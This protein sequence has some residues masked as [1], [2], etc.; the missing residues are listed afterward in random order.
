MPR[1]SVFSV[2]LALGTF[3]FGAGIAY[4]FFLGVAGP[5]SALRGFRLEGWIVAASF[6]AVALSVL[7]AA[8]FG[9]WRVGRADPA[10]IF[11]EAI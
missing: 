1:R 8:A 7:S 4:A 10:L 3:G 6:A 5:D 9:L 2:F 11:R